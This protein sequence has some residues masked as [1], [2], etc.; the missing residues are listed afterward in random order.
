MAMD[1]ETQEK[2]QQ[3]QMFE[4]NLQ[5]ILVQKQ[6]FQFELSEAENALKEV[7]KTKDDI[8]KMTGQI[9]IKASKNEVEK[10]LKQKK[11]LLSLRVKALE[12][13]ESQF[14]EELEKLKEEVMKK[15]K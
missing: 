5:N 8:F 2:I 14:K 11:D 1:K 13:Q 9:M 4:Q 15:I 3:L 7:E 10:D 12:K 6:A